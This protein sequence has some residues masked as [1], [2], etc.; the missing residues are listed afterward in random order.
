MLDIIAF[1]EARHHV[2]AHASEALPGSPIRP[3]DRDHN[4]R[5][6]LSVALHHLAERLDPQPAS[7]PSTTAACCS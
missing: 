7:H 4:L 5:H 6:R 1:L 2:A 3:D